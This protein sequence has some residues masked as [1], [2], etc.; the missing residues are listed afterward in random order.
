MAC[1]TVLASCTLDVWSFADGIGNPH[2]CQIDSFI[3][4]LIK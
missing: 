3:Q 4:V 1:S 2:H